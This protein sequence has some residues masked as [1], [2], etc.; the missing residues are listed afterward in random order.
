MTL[1]G[2]LTDFKADCNGR[3]VYL[4]DHASLPLPRQPAASEN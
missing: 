4:I 3:C 2:R 1:S